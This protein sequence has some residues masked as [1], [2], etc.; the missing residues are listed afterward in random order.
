MVCQTGEP[1]INASELAAHTEMKAHIITQI[2]ND[3][4]TLQTYSNNMLKGTY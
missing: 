4:R 3:T 2:Y 1:T